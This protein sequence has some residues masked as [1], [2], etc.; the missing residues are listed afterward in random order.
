MIGIVIPAY[1]RKEALKGALESLVNQTYKDFI[2]FVIDDNSPEPLEET[3]KEF[4]SK[5]NIVYKYLEKNGG[6]GVARQTGL[7]LCYEKQLEFVM[8]LDS[9]DWLYENAVEESLNLI[10]EHDVDVVSSPFWDEANEIEIEA[11]NQV[12]VHG[13]IY[14]TD[15]LRK[16]KI[17]FP[18]MRANE[19]VAFNKKVFLFEGVKVFYSKN[20]IHIFKDE[21]NS[22]TRE[23]NTDTLKKI[24]SIN[25]IESIYDIVTFFEKHGQLSNVLAVEVFKDLYLAYQTGLFYDLI[26]EEIKNKIR[27]IFS[28]DKIKRLAKNK[29]FLKMICRDIPQCSTVVEE[30]ILFEQSYK[31]WLEEFRK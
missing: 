20:I 25:S 21:K 23:K 29:H 12:W 3:V 26:T 6:P 11:T 1:K 10:Q 5:L 2:T 16:N 27:Y 24:F 13:K 15:F 31:Q 22:I 14:R 8:F 7:E 19:D 17:E 18:P 9:D 28:N 30:P 4:S